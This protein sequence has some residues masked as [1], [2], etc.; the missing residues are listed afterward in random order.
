MSYWSRY[1]LFLLYLCV[2]VCIYYILP[3]VCNVCSFLCF[4]VCT[5]IYHLSVF[6]CLLRA[7]AFHT[8]SISC[9]HAPRLCASGTHEYVNRPTWKNSFGRNENGDVQ[10]SSI[11][12][13][14]IGAGF[15]IFELDFSKRPSRVS[16]F[17]I[18]RNSLISLTTTDKD[19]RYIRSPMTCIVLHDS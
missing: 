2:L 15:R 14:P 3:Y 5:F 8:I 1:K 7:R 6:L 16:T 19:S 10:D 13:K 11:S 4:S 9:M 12:R 18:S 17:K